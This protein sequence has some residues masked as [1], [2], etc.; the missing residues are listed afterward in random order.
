MRSQ[1]DREIP[2][3]VRNAATSDEVGRPT[4]GV[5]QPKLGPAIRAQLGR[6]GCYRVRQCLELISLAAN[7]RCHG[8][9]LAAKVI[10]A[11]DNTRS[12]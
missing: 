10:F 12:K 7:R 4:R 8:C 6:K 11:H 9:W 5:A 3:R 1:R 2:L